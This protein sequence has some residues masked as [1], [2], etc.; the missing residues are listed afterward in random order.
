MVAGIR[1][2]GYIR[3]LKKQEDTDEKASVPLKIFKKG[4]D[5]EPDKIVLHVKVH[6]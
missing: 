2:P 1:S 5:D 4:K 3:N 6:K